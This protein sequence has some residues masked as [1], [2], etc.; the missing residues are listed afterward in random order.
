MEK[1]ILWIIAL[2]LIFAL[3]YIAWGILMFLLKI[4]LIISII[5]ALGY[6]FYRLSKKE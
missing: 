5:V 6:V 4:F 1:I 2:F 3:L